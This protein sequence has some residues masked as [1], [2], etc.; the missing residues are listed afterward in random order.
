M[1]SNLSVSYDEN[2]LVTITCDENSIV[3]D[4]RQTAV[5]IEW[6]AKFLYQRVKND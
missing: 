3:V 2:G 6:L 4:A 1:N 5:L